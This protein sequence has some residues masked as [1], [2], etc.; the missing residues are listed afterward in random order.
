M[1]KSAEADINHELLLWAR[2]SAGLRVERA[3]RKLGVT[4]GRLEDWESGRSRP[5][6]VQLRKAANVY[7]R[8]FAVFFL[9]RAPAPSGLPRDFRRVV[10][11][12]APQMSPELLLELRRA[13]RRRTIA[14]EIAEDLEA[15]AP[16]SPPRATVADDPDDVAARGRTWLG[17]GLGD[18]ARWQGTY[19]ALNGWIA[20]FENR[21]VLV[22]QTSEVSLAEMRGFSLSERAWPAI[23]LNAKDH[24]RARV[25]T[26]MHEFTHLML[27]Q[28]GLC[29]PERVGWRAARSQDER[30]EVYCNRVAGALLVPGDAL[31]A[32]A[33]VGAGRRAVSWDEPV[34]RDLADR[35]AVSREVILRRLVILGRATS[36]FYE[37]K[38][39]EYLEQY[40]LQTLR[41]R[42]REGH[43]PLYRIA[44]RD[45]GR[46]FTR[47]VLEAL[48]RDRITSADVSDYLG[49]RLKHLPDIAGLIQRRL[50]EA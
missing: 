28:P 34:I 12:E 29:D 26:L 35:F 8:P 43:A 2:E 50:A 25:F 1:A 5:T 30:I 23:V 49:V 36:A 37:R 41:A 33:R 31:W 44:V 40:R 42:E 10:G 32:D 3:A 21:G 18:Q 9:P 19:D 13:R 39:E 45:N 11:V 27:S 48:E 24:P 38:R 16:P 14:L 20:A 4:A 47:L 7:K 15:T 46:R 17:P 6:V 22:F